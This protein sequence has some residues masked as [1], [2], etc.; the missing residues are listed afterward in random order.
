MKILIATD[1]SHCADQAQENLLRAGLPPDAEVTILS[2]ADVWLPPE[3]VDT[4]LPAELNNVAQKARA[5][6]EDA[7][8]QSTHHARNAASKIGMLFPS[9]NLHSEAIADSP[10]WGIISRAEQL[11]ADLVVVGSQG[12]SGIGKLVQGSVS[13]KVV[14]H[15]H[16]PVRVGR[17]AP[18]PERQQI[19]LMLA[20]DGSPGSLRTI[21][22]ISNRPWPA[23]TQVRIVAVLDPRLSTAA[24][25]YLPHAAN[26]IQEGYRD[27]EAW[28]RSVVEKEAGKLRESG[29]QVSTSIAQGDP[30]LILLEFAR[31]WE[32]DTIFVGA[33]GL[34]RIERFLLGSVSGAVA[35]RATCSVE[36]VRY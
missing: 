35:S 8:A 29:L 10:G 15:A 32:A 30:K 5:L 7:L 4:G 9:W 20:M 13:Q 31:N 17:P 14:T 24:I 36:I 2:V 22:H 16:C 26:W 27:E 21:E 25:S 12:L 33:R 6:A 11:K 1:G 28:I 34:T 18:Q 19:R 23:D 3:H